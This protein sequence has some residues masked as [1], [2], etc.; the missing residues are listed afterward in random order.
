[1]EKLRENIAKLWKPHKPKKLLPLM[2]S[3][4][5]IEELM[6][7]IDSFLNHWITMGPKVKSFEE[8]FT[9]YIGVQNATMVNSGSSANLLALSILSNPTIEDRI[10]PGDEIIVPSV[11]WSTSIFPIVNIGSIPT[12]SDVGEDYQID[13]ESV[14]ENISNKTKAIMAVHLLGDACDIK[15]LRDLANDHKL[16][17]L[18]DCCESLGTE[19]DGKKV[20]T[21]SDISTFSFYFSHHITTGEGG[22]LC[23][24]NPDYSDLSK[25]M[26][27]HGY[28]RESSKKEKYISE[29]PN[30]DP[31]FLFVNLGYN[32]RPTDI[33]GAIALQQMKRL[34]KFLNRRIE[35]AEH[36][37]RG[38]KSYEEHLILPKRKGNVK[39]SW[40]AFPLTI[41]E[42]APF[43]KG[44]ITKYLEGKGIETRPLVCGNFA[45]QPALNLFTNKSKGLK[46][47]EYIMRNSFY[48]G[49][50]PF[51]DKETCNK[52]IKVFDSFFQLLKR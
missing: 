35:A 11:T 10:K 1:M 36:I 16:F 46:N 41:R 34:E 33:Q 29:N 4:I 18:E 12:L 26:R 45:E 40:F 52:V 50:H 17:L 30:I 24:G 43:S 32:I 31:R 15:A 47:A 2:V 20:G 42:G 38:L 44:E 13:I 6:E 48:F 27:A 51:I 28:V 3:S 39:H 23:T 5:G 21:F 22:M 19:I 14:K 49:I 37:L 8:E 25:I 7:V 9:N